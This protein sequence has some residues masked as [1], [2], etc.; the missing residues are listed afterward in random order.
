MANPTDFRFVS[1]LTTF[2][3]LPLLSF[4]FQQNSA[5]QDS[6][7]IEQP[8]PISVNRLVSEM[9]E[10]RTLIELNKKK[11]APTPRLSR[12]DSLYPDY[13]GFIT[14]EEARARRFVTSNPNRQK[15]V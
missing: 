1:L 8:E 5:T 10:L 2:L 15:I 13:K 7:L 6:V 12:I 3:F 14:D 11:I 9:E 4:A